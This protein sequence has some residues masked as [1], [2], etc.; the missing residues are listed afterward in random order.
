MEEDIREILVKLDIVGDDFIED[1]AFAAINL[2]PTVTWAKFILTDDKP[3]ANKQRVPL[4]EFDNLIKTGVY[5]PVKLEEDATL[6]P[7]HALAKP[8]GVIS[9]LKTVK[10][11]IHGLAALWNEERPEDIQEIKDKFKNNESINLSW[12]IKYKNSTISE[13]GVQDLKDIALKAATIVGMPSYQGRTPFLA[14]AEEKKKLED[15]LE[16]KIKELEDKVED[17]KTQ[18]ATREDIIKELSPLKD[19][20]AELQEF[21]DTVISEREAEA[22]FD[23]LKSKFK[24]ASLEKDDEYFETNKELLLGMEKSSLDFMLQEMVAFASKNDNGD[25]DDADA[26]LNEGLPKITGK[27]SKK[28]G[29]KEIAKLLRELDK[30]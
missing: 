8:L 9:H 19:T 22:N 18:L 24:D 1:E 13:D 28:Y 2:N 12:E 15:I 6:P 11:Q 5:M 21:K 20:V 25:S 29:P 23:E 4:E 3:N 14:L 17:L 10:N 16:K 30:S 7:G 27:T 26:S